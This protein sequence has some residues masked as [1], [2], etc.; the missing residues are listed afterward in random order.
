[1]DVGGWLGVEVDWG[2]GGRRRRE[3]GTGNGRDRYL[4]CS[5]QRRRLFSRC[6]E[7][8][9]RERRLSSP[10]RAELAECEIGLM[11]WCP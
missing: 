7:S 8:R 1:M 2:V 3:G 4:S 11:W 10:A 9:T 6:K 5:R